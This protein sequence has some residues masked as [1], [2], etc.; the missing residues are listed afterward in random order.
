MPDSPAKDRT[1]L[2][3]HKLLVALKATGTGTHQETLV[4]QGAPVQPVF[5][6]GRPVARHTDTN[7]DVSQ[8][9]L[10]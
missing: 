3:I 4:Q 10:L 7:G 6:V 2:E 5:P 1:K 9:F 8:S